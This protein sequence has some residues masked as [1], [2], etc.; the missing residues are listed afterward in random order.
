MLLPAK[1]S[2]N[3]T[4]RLLRQLSAVAVSIVPVSPCTDLDITLFLFLK[5]SNQRLLQL[6][7]VCL[8]Y[9]AICKRVCFLHHYGCGDDKVGCSIILQPRH[10]CRF[11]V[12]ELR[13]SNLLC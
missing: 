9:K 12:W 11:K 4:S 1:L 10:H 2:H 7:S 13:P 3:S 6:K 8:T 5:Q